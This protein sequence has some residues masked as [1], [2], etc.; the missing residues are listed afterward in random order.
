[1]VSI[2]LCT[3]AVTM[4]SIMT[5]SC[6]A[7]EPPPPQDAIIRAI[8]KYT[9]IFLNRTKQPFYTI[10]ADFLQERPLITKGNYLSSLKAAGL[11]LQIAVT[12]PLRR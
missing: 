8:I 6:C 11:H 12:T 3:R 5:G 10:L 9:K 2:G 4:G 7:E 1:M